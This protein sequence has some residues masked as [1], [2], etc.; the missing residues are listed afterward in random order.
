MGIVLQQTQEYNIWPRTRSL[1]QIIQTSSLQLVN[2]CPC[3]SWDAY[4]DQLM[5]TWGQNPV[6]VPSDWHYWSDTLRVFQGVILRRV[7]QKV[8]CLLLEYSSVTISKGTWKIL[9][10]FYGII[11]GIN[12]MTSISGKLIGQFLSEGR[13]PVFWSICH[14]YSQK[15]GFDRIYQVWKKRFSISALTVVITM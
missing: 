2:F 12:C 10:S 15:H 1:L 7:S 11:Y 9:L 6:Y 4:P 13:K 5:F 8:H 14:A 3:E